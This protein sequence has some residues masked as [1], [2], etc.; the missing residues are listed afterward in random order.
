MATHTLWQSNKA[1]R[2]VLYLRV[3]SEKRLQY[4]VLL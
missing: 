1:A 4:L 3:L 2:D